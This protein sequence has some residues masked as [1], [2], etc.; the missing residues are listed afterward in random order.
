MESI[1]SISE[2][3]EQPIEKASFSL[4]VETAEVKEEASEE[5]EQIEE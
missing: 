2:P 3:E 5:G 1:Q 4:K